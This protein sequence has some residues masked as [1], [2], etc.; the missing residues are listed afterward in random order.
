MYNVT[1]FPKTPG[2]WKKVINVAKFDR[3]PMADQTS[4]VSWINHYSKIFDTVIYAVLVLPPFVLICCLRKSFSF[5]CLLLVLNVSKE[6]RR[7]LNRNLIISTA[8][9]LFTS[10]SIQRL[11][12][13]LQVFFQMGLFSSLVPHFF[14]FGNITSILNRGKDPTNCASYKPITVAST[15]SKIFGCFAP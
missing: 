5:M 10:V 8:S 9:V 13:H 3:P 6:V 4:N 12:Y 1:R 11:V 15:L 7:D 14:L 2:Q